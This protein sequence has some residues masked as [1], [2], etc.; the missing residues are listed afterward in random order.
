MVHQ[1]LASTL[2]GL[3]STHNFAEGL[4]ADFSRLTHDVY[5]RRRLYQPHHLKKGA[6]AR[7][8]QFMIRTILEDAITHEGTFL[9]RNERKYLMSEFH[10]YI[11]GEE[12]VFHPLGKLAQ[13]FSQGVYRER[14]TT[15][16]SYPTSLLEGRSM[17]NHTSSAPKNEVAP[18]TPDLG[19]SHISLK[20]QSV[21]SDQAC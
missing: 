10:V 14:L 4:T 15:S 20:R 16:I 6:R 21:S 7:N 5:L 3:G 8:W 17:L 9:G 2:T 19:P 18:S 13:L 12:Y 11:R 1:L